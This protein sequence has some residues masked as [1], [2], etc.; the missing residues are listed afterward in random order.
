MP[1]CLRA[2]GAYGPKI[3]NKIKI[4]LIKGKVAPTDLLAASS[5]KIIKIEPI[6]TSIF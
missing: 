3:A 2:P 1:P 5:V 4:I 6:N